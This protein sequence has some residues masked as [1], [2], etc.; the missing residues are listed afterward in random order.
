MP[1]NTL[2]QFSGTADS[3]RSRRKPSTVSAQTPRIMHRPIAAPSANPSESLS[4]T[5]AQHVLKT[6]DGMIDLILDGDPTTGGLE[7]TVVDL[8]VLP[9]RLLRPGLISAEQLRRFLPNLEIMVRK[10]QS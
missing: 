7:S 9:P 5:T 8:S 4:P 6:L 2:H 3:L 1:F 10:E